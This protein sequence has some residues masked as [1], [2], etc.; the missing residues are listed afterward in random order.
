M[1][2]VVA[3]VEVDHVIDKARGRKIC[4]RGGGRAVINENPPL[5]PQRTI[6]YHGSDIYYLLVWRVICDDCLIAQC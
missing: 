1:L 2:S 5:P 6:E 3:A 4:K